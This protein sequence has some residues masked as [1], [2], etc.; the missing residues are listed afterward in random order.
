MSTSKTPRL[1][2]H[3]WTG[4]DRFSRTE[5]NENFAR[6]DALEAADISLSSAQF[7]E[8]NVKAA[9]ESLKS[10]VSSG[11]ALLTTAVTDKGG[12]IPGSE[13]HT[14][15][16]IE[17]GIRSIPAGIDTSDATAVATDILSGK[18]A[19]VKGAKVTGTMPNRGAGGTVTPTTSDQTKLS[20]YYSSPI[21]IKG[22]PNLIPANI[23]AGKTIFGVA[24]TVVAGKPFATGTV[25]AAGSYYTVTGLTFRP[26]YAFGWSTTEVSGSPYPSFFILADGNII[27]YTYSGDARANAMLYA[28]STTIN[29]RSAGSSAQ[30]T[31]DGFSFSRLYSGD[32]SYNW[33]A[34]GW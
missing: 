21:T 7:T 27:T 32:G 9:L 5:I 20:G 34:I 28:Y 25:S 17:Q 2:L 24:G 3:S 22:D 26:K 23:L 33:F 18:T 30:V 6:L 8:T 12:A 10:S 11:K 19:Y 16:E 1:S 4:T 14:F 31:D 13:P 15:A 29:V